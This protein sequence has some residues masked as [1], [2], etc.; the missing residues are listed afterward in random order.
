MPKHVVYASEKDCKSRIDWWIN[1]F[2]L[3]PLL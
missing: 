3:C 2:P 1:L